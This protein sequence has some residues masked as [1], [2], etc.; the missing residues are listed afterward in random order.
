M[1]TPVLLVVAGLSLVL[2]T[3]IVCPG[4]QPI[5]AVRVA[6]GLSAPVHVTAPEGDPRLFV[7]ERRGTIQVLDADG[8]PGVLPFLDLSARTNGSGEQGLLGLAFAPDYAA[9]GL[10][11]VNYTNLSGDTVI[12]RYRVSA[13]PDFALPQS[14]EILLTIDQPFSNHNGGH[15]AF[16]PDEMLYIGM[17]DGGDAGDPGNRAQDPTTLLGKMLRIDVSGGPG[18]GYRIPP[19]NPFASPTDGVRD[20]IWASGLRNPYRFFLDPFFGGMLVIGDVGQAAL[21]ELDAELLAGSAGS[22]YGWRRKEGTACFNPAQNCDDGTLVD[23]VHEY[24]HSFGRCAIVDGPTYY[25]TIWEIW[26][27]HFFGDFC[28]GEIWSVVLAAGPS[29]VTV[30]ELRN[31]TAELVPDVGSIDLISGFGT[32][33]LRQLYVMDLDGEIFEILSAAP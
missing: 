8:N 22:N 17:G 29:G 28:T 23:P 20:E 31:R 7:V 15:L 2:G 11:Y 32:G 14:E 10:F 6:A 13:I 21:E 9:S 30:A 4:P 5:R 3:G 16:G 19:G 27:R 33:G 24:D 26:G 18:S 25:G 1:R 12:A